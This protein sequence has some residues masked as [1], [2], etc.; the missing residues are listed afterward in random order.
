MSLTIAIV[1]TINHKLMEFALEKTIKA[2]PYDKI[3]VFSDKKLDLSVP[4]EFF[5]LTTPFTIVDYSNFLLKD[6]NSY[7][8]TEH[9]LSIQYDGFPVRPEYWTDEFLKYDFIGSLMCPSHPPLKLSMQKTDNEKVQHFLK[10]REWRNGG[11]GLT[12]RSKKFLEA[13]ASKEF[14]T[15]V[16]DKTGNHA[17]SCED[18]SVSYDHRETLENKYGI[19]FAS[20]SDSLNFS[21]EIATG[22]SHALGFHGW[23]NTPLF[24][25]ED[26]VIYYIYNMQNRKIREH[27]EFDIFLGFLVQKGYKKAY[28]L[29][30]TRTY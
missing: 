6:L 7:I 18:Y 26:E 4:Y 19:K 3:K 20:L 28:S 9:T 29:F 24:L 30:H 10:T 8:D 13:L 15:L 25:S 1:G 16:Y 22:Y 5:K 14:D 17:W 11:G 23:Q 12:L 21:V 2:V 27:P